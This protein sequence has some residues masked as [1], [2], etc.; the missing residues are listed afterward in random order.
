MKPFTSGITLYCLSLT[1]LLFLIPNTFAC[2]I[3]SA[4]A[5]NGEVWNANNEDGPF[6]VAN[7]LNVYPK[8][9]QNE[10]GYYTLSYFSPRFGQTGSIQ[11]GTNE[12]GLTF[13]FNAIDAV[14]T[15]EV[16]SKKPFPK[17]DNAILVHLLGTMSSVEEVIAFFETYWFENG[18]TGAQMH[19]ADA[20]GNFAIISPSGIEKAAT[21]QPLVSTN[22]DR[23]GKEDGSSCWRYPIAQSMLE[24]QDVSFEAMEEIL[25][26]TAQKNGATMYSNI[27]NLTTGQLWFFSKHD[28]G[29]LVTT[30]MKALLENGKQSYSFSD[31]DAIHASQE[32]TPF[33]EPSPVSLSKE[34]QQKFEGRYNNWYFG[35]ITVKLQEA[36]LTVRF[37]D[38][39]ETVLTPYEADR[40]FIPNEGVTLTFGNDASR[41]KKTLSLSEDG[42]WSFTAWQK[43]PNH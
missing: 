16:S 26:K 24:Q 9:P 27:Q 25:K 42:F 41:D 18:F 10:Y 3:V 35:S 6:G 30:T 43:D 20:Q 7:F 23:C 31:L 29:N 17:G 39:F 2:T 11:G 1:F 22:F 37:P 21:G 19:V 40:F 4:I 32:T 38:G 36:G 33:Q 12:A 14:N 34:A 15:S 8:S 5:H 28:E 13:D